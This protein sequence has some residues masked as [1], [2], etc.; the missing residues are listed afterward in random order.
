MID[1]ISSLLVDDINPIDT[2]QNSVFLKRIP[3]EVYTKMIHLFSNEYHFQNGAENGGKM[4]INNYY[5]GIPR[6]LSD[7]FIAFI[8]EMTEKLSLDQFPSLGTPE[9]FEPDSDTLLPTELEGGFSLGSFD[10]AVTDDGLQNIEFQSVATY[11]VSAAKLNQCLLDHMQLDNAFVFADSPA[12]KWSDFIDFYKK[13]IADN[14]TTGI[15]LTDRKIKEQ[16]TNFE[17]FATQKELDIPIEIVDM[18]HI[19]EKNN[20][21]FYTVPD[22]QEKPIKINRLYNRILLAEALFEDNY[23]F[24]AHK[25]KFRFDKKYNA[26]KFINHPI[27]Q[28]EVSKRLS[29]YISHACNPECFELSE[30]ASLFRQ[31]D[32][33]YEDYVWKHKWGA[34][35]HKLVLEPT[36]AILDSLSDHLEEYIAQR[37]VVFKI[38]KTEDGLE[39]IIELRYMTAIHNRKM[40]IVPMARIGHVTQE[41]NGTHN[42]KIHF[43]DNNK[44]GY[45][46][47]P[48]IIFD[49]KVK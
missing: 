18:E 15:V 37:K 19:F 30:A 44:E 29:P 14:Q 35:G 11:P 13:I 4:R 7:T 17:F 23:P 1:K 16:K 21:L 24:D 31:G 10:M 46:F 49:R 33:R 12:T 27:K 28:F 39:K 36:P 8:N 34:A 41:P 32:L 3:D 20:E 45:G 38:F 6:V 9:G 48:V 26:L 2:D 42:F 25:W 47:S 22:T 43:G 40:M 5:V